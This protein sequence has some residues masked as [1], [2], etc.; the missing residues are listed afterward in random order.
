MPTKRI[1]SGWL[2]SASDD[3][4]IGLY[5][6]E[7]GEVRRVRGH[8]GDVYSV[9]FTPDSRRLVS[10]SADRTVG[11]TSV[12]GGPMR[13]LPGHELLVAEVQ[14]SP[15]GRSAAAPR[16]ELLKS[17]G[18]IPNLDP[19]ALSQGNGALDLIG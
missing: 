12:E 11:L 6:L 15:D 4:T 19:L 7:S 18:Q 13:R 16:G 2:A 17:L 3:R 9:A 10:G 14:I 1:C 8:D 5:S